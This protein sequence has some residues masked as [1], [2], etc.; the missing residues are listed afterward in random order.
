MK[1]LALH[2]AIKD[3]GHAPYNDR[4]LESSLNDAHAMY[5]IC[6]TLGYENL[7]GTELVDWDGSIVMDGVM[8]VLYDDMATVD[9]VKLNIQAI[10]KQLHA[11]DVFLLT[12]SGHGS[13]VKDSSLEGGSSEAL[14]L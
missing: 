4:S 2:I 5:Q 11:G 8:N 6:R 7:D 13:S 3:Y 10:C 1:G 12:Y 14:C 9:R